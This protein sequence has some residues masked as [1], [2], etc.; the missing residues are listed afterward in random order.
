VIVTHDARAA[1]I[2]DRVVFLNDGL[3]VADRSKLTSDE[4]LDQIKSLE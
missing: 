2:A 1:A 4:I 3:I